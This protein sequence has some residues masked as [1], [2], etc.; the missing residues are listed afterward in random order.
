VQTLEAFVLRSRREAEESIEKLTKEAETLRARLQKVET[1]LDRWKG[2]RDALNQ[3]ASAG[4]KAGQGLDP[5][6]SVSGPGPQSGRWQ[7]RSP[8]VPTEVTPVILPPPE[9][10]GVKE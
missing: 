1:A 4:A 10:P 5:I 2:V 7:R 3:E 6:S 9:L 8:G